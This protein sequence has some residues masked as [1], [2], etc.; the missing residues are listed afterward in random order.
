MLFLIPRLPAVFELG[1]ELADSMDI[2]VSP[3]ANANT[4]NTRDWRQRDNALG[5]VFAKR[6]EADSNLLGSFTCRV[7]GHS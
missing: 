2:F 1:Q 3:Q 5:D 4:S 7:A 6:R